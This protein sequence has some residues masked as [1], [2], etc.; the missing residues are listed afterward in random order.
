M[1][2]AARRSS[3]MDAIGIGKLTR[4]VPRE[5]VEPVTRLWGIHLTGPAQLRGLP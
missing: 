4:P 3:L 1:I 5:L 2:N